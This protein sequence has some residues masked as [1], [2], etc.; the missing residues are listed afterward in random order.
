MTENT[1]GAADTA[2]KPEQSSNKPISAFGFSTWTPVLSYAG[3]FDAPAYLL[4]VCGSLLTLGQVQQCHSLV[5]SVEKEFT[6]RG[7]D[8]LL[9][10]TTSLLAKISFLNGRYEDA[11]SMILARRVEMDQAGDA[12]ELAQH[13]ELLVQAY[14]KMDNLEEARQVALLSL[15]LLED[16]SLKMIDRGAIQQKVQQNAPTAAGAGAGATTMTN[17]AGVATSK[18]TI[19]NSRTSL[20]ASAAA[21]VAGNSRANTAASRKYGGGGTKGGAGG[22]GGG[23][24]LLIEASLQNITAYL[25]VLRSYVAVTLQNAAQQVAESTDPR[26]L[27]VELCERLGR[28]ADLMADI[29]G[30]VSGLVSEV[31]T[32]RASAAIEFLSLLHQRASGVVS[33]VEE[34]A[35]WMSDNVLMCVEYLN[36]VVDMNKVLANS[37][38][39]GEL[40]YT[41]E[42][43][44][45]EAKA[46]STG[47]VA[48]VP[49]KE[50]S[51]PVVRTLALSQIQLAYVHVVQAVIS[52]DHAS[53]TVNDAYNAFQAES[54]R[55]AVDK[56]LEVTKPPPTFDLSDF[57]VAGLTKAAQLLSDCSCLLGGVTTAA[58]GGVGGAGAGGGVAATAT[59]SPA[60]GVSIIDA[61][62]EVELL[63]AAALMLQQHR[64]GLF[65]C[66]WGKPIVLSTGKISVTNSQD[67]TVTTDTTATIKTKLAAATS[68]P[69]PASGRKASTA[70]AVAVVEV[71]EP[72]IAPYGDAALSAD[73]K[74]ARA[75]LAEQTRSLVPKCSTQCASA[76]L[77]GAP[78]GAAVPSVRVL[79]YACLALVEAFGTH[80]PAAAAMW[81]LQL[82]SVTSST[83]LRTV[84]RD[85]AL[86]PTGAVA[87]SV[88]RLEELCSRNWPCKGPILQIQAEQEL[89]NNASVAFKRYVILFL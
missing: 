67:L 51:N 16:V 20:G 42:K 78:A 74:E 12:K 68:S 50:I 37:I 79:Q 19:K 33:P 85:Y 59:S 86:N 57:A 41:S 29:A 49:Y 55:T 46:S 27:Y 40:T 11:V 22:G 76:G 8:R 10:Q 64:E 69:A 73:A 71:P 13:T 63:R 53:R 4:Q 83:W 9:I 45:A 34:Y 87:G 2:I 61:V 38:P 56:F 31:L 35:S 77:N 66:M 30:E 28:C 21:S 24:S 84:W 89:L 7:D 14:L 47:Q 81:L 5:L 6:Q 1:A 26:P 82:H 36:K 80:R 48:K 65:D 43:L 17:G 52:G 3:G 75:A 54:A 88:S 62:V 23:S 72:V 60:P 58:A 18:A 15:Q 39:A 44:F 25:K 70:A 32:L